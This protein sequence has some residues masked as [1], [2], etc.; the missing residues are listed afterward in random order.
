MQNC[1]ASSFKVVV[2]LYHFLLIWLGR[3]SLSFVGSAHKTFTHEQKEKNCQLNL[4]VSIER[5]E[6][7]IVHSNAKQSKNFRKWAV[8]LCRVYS[9]YSAFGIRFASMW[10]RRCTWWSAI[11]HQI[12]YAEHVIFPW[13]CSPPCE[14]AAHSMPAENHNGLFG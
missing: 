2:M 11:A 1:F 10:K 5:N 7:E 6:F 14:K 8:L 12:I 9:R 4:V 13:H 3:K